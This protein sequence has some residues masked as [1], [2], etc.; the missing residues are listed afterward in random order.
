[1]KNRKFNIFIIAIVLTATLFFVFSN[2]NERKTIF[3]QIDMDSKNISTVE[4][5]DI[6]ANESAWL[7]DTDIEQITS[8]LLKLD[9]VDVITII[10]NE[11][12]LYLIY[13]SNIGYSPG[14]P[15]AVFKHRLEYQGESIQLSYEESL[16]IVK[17]LEKQFDY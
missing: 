6:H 17:L 3:S 13:I 1:M 5:Y 8:I 4:V 12:P 11:K 2:E 16:M 7:S 10:N 9:T 15:I 14:P